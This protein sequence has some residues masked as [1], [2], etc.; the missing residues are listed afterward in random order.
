MTIC[1]FQY[2]FAEFIVENFWISDM[3]NSHNETFFDVITHLPVILPL[4]KGD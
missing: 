1:F 4:L 2:A 3:C